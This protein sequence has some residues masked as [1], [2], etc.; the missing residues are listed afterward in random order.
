MPGFKIHF[1]VGCGCGVAIGAGSLLMGVPLV[2]CVVAGTFC[3]IGGILPD[4]DSASGRPSREVFGVLGATL[5][6][7]MV[8]RMTELNLAHDVQVLIAIVSYVVI[9]FGMARVLS[10][11]CVHRGMWHS[12]PAA[13]AA[14]MVMFLLAECA[15]VRMRYF[16]A[17]AVLIGYL[18][19]L[20][21]DEI[22]SVNLQGTPRLKKSFGTALKL[23]SNKYKTATVFVYMLFFAL[24][25]AAEQRN[26]MLVAAAGTESPG[27]ESPESFRRWRL[28]ASDTDSSP[29]VSPRESAEV[30]DGTDIPGV[31][32]AIRAPVMTGSQAAESSQRVSATGMAGAG[33]LGGAWSAP[34]VPLPAAQAQERVLPQS[35]ASPVPNIGPPMTLPP[36][37]APW[38]VPVVHDKLPNPAVA[39]PGSPVPTTG[40]PYAPVRFSQ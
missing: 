8:R 32:V 4:M 17:G 18:S 29:G 7:M 30:P 37:V 19:H 9:R 10:R 12:L 24:L 21:M 20:L 23:W 40:L 3:S 28:F 16:R 39:P 5:P 2:D 27:T 22:W 25:L 11:I 6:M 34:G 13:G 38:S 33:E 14:A 15:D 31:S 1:S 35:T 26:A 36:V